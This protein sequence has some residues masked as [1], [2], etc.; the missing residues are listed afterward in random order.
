MS[1]QMLGSFK[2]KW[3]EHGRARDGDAT[4]KDKRGERLFKLLNILK[5]SVV[6]LCKFT[7]KELK[8]PLWVV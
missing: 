4:K 5:V 8:E 7:R 1:K 6:T 3:R 2:Q